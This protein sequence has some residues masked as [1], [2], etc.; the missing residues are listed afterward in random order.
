MNM[1]LMIAKHCIVNRTKSQHPETPNIPTN[2]IKIK[3]S[4]CKGLR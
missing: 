1:E 2:L 3:F 4:Q